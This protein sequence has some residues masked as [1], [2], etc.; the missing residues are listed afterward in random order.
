MKY[1]Y[2]CL[3]MLLDV[4]GALQD[5]IGRVSGQNCKIY[6]TDPKK[7]AISEIISLIAK[8]PR[9]ILLIAKPS[10]L[11]N[12]LLPCWLILGPVVQSE[13]FLTMFSN[14]IAPKQHLSNAHN[15]KR[16]MK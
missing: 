1:V 7:I 16:F 6:T 13:A 10:D 11:S 14:F 5:R 3:Y 2:Y 9:C 4:Y 15:I 12:F 8:L